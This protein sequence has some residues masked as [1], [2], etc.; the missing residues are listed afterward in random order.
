[1]IA[2]DDPVSIVRAW[3]DRQ[4]GWGRRPFARRVPIMIVRSKRASRRARAGVWPVSAA[5]G[6]DYERRFIIP[7]AGS[8]ASA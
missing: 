6:V 2:T 5:A 8:A 4:R 3:R 7:L 1:M